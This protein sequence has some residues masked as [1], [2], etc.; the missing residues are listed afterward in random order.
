[1]LRVLVAL[2]TLQATFSVHTEIVAVPVSV[3][4]ADGNVVRGLPR[5]AFSVRED[6]RPRPVELFEPGDGPAGIGVVADYSQSMRPDVATM[7][8]GLA[9]LARSLSS[10]DEFFVL[11]FNDEPPSESRFMRTTDPNAIEKSFSETRPA[12]GTA[13]YD[14]LIAGLEALQRTPLEKRGLIVVSDGGDNASRHTL[15]DVVALARRS[16]AVIYAAVIARAPRDRRGEDV[17]RRLARDTGGLAKVASPSEL[18]AVLTQFGADMRAQYLIGFVPGGGT[19]GTR[20]IDVA[21]A[22]RPPR[23][24]RV[25]ARSSYSR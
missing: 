20:S 9:A 25:R 19:K 7:A 14:G 4:D 17:L 13:L 21:V 16:N 6:G 3:T 23:V 1:V 5:D 8:S 11:P 22:T 10:R 18:G 2:M 15:D 24:L 12:G